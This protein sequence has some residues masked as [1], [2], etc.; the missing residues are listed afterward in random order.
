MPDGD[1][2]VL[3]VMTAARMLQMVSSLALIPQLP[4]LA[5]GLKPAVEAWR[6]LPFAG[7]LG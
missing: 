1:P 5:E 2:E 7:G 4:L 3:Q 6:A